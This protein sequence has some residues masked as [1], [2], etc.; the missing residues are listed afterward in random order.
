MLFIYCNTVVLYFTVKII[1]KEK[2]FQVLRIHL[3]S[4]VVYDENI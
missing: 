4:S 3:N 2:C 1:L